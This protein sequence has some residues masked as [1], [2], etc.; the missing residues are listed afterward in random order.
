MLTSRAGTVRRLRGVAARI[1][2]VSGR[3]CPPS[4]ESGTMSEA[5]TRCSRRAMQ[6]AHE[7]DGSVSA[8]SD[9]RTRPQRKRHEGLLTGA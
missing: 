5:A 1:G 9:F 6:C 2:E 4:A 3:M 8:V 7:L